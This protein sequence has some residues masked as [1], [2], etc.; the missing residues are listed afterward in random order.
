MAERQAPEPIVI[1]AVGVVSPI[2]HSAPIAYTSMRAGL[3]RL[4]LSPELRIRDGRGK[5]M[6]VVCGA[7]TGVTDGHRRFLRLYRMALRA[8]SEALAQGRLAASD[9]SDTHVYLCL[10]EAERPGLDNR[11]ATGLMRKAC[12]ALGL[13]DL[14][15][16]T[17]VG[18]H[19]HAG[20]L[21]ALQTACRSVAS[22]ACRRA[23]VVGVDTYLDELSLQW[24][25]DTGRLK[26]EGQAKG[27]V[28]GEGAAVLLIEQ[29]SSARARQVMPLA[30]VAGVGAAMET[31]TIFDKKPST[32]EA[33][34]Q[35]L[36][37]ATRQAG[38]CPLVVC[39]LNG[40]RYR[41]QEW[42]LVLA[43]TQGAQGAQLTWHAADC[44]GDAG[45]A[46][47][48]LSLV[49]AAMALSRRHAPGNAALIWGASDDGERGAAVLQ[50]MPQAA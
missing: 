32:G 30:Q 8:W 43:R 20:P 23:F 25:A 5:L 18:L 2:G 42:G 40:E 47:G 13:P 22:G 4:G 21:M 1:S 28:P 7:A 11:A 24:L 34:T 26:V 50:A 27:F 3:S 6:S 38:P 14:S 46:S 12:A 31:Q 35:A 19:G 15:S 16:A 29:A 41:A 10:A 36:R 49:W 39:D 17:A 44:M 48:A 9:L 45:A 37:A 33:L